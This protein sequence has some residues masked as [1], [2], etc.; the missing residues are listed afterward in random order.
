MAVGFST[1]G[2]GGAKGASVA[3]RQFI[4]DMP[5]IA[6]GMDPDESLLSGQNA[7]MLVFYYF[8]SVVSIPYLLYKWRGSAEN[9][10]GANYE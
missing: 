1:A 5:E 10:E 3:M 4:S 2:Y 6:P 7:L 8:T 9:V